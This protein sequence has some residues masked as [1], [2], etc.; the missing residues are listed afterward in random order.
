MRALYLPDLDAH[1]C[2]HDLGGHE[3]VC[4]YL[5]GLGLASSADVPA[6]A[7]HPLL[8]PYRA[9]LVDLLGFGFSDHP[10]AFPHTLEA[11]AP[12]IAHL[13]D[14]LGLR[15]C[16]LV[17]HSLGGTIA[18][19]LAA[20]CPDLVASLVVAEPNLEPEDTTLSRTIADQTEA[21]YVATG[22]A[23]LVARA[24]TWAA[25]DPAMSTYPS[26]LRAADPRAMHRSAAALV[27]VSL[28]QTFLALTLPRTYVFGAQTLPHHHEAWLRVAGVAVAVVPDAGHLMLTGNPDGVA[29]VIAA[30][31]PAPDRDA[32]RVTPGSASP[33]GHPTAF[34]TVPIRPG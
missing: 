19:V 29:R 16:H 28:R 15:D 17:G 27:T 18:I 1:L 2:Y 10:A 26:T 21:E 23:T 7:R 6:I 30:S 8:A 22:H 12:T 4:V 11:H 20:A 31:L 13:L 24:E 9:L 34:V 3:P 32:E 25:E 33:H 14:H 5:H